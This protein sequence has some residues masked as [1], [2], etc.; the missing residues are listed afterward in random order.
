MPAVLLAHGSPDPRHSEA[1]ESQAEIL[2]ER[3]VE[4]V[5]AYLDHQG[6]SLKEVFAQI[7]EAQAPIPVIPLLI[8]QAFHA[9]VDV[10]REVS[11]LDRSDVVVRS[12]WL[13]DET[14]IAA[15]DSL[16]PPQ[17]SPRDALV[18]VTAGSS[19]PAALSADD[20]RAASWARSRGISNYAA[21][22]ASGPGQRPSTAIAAARAAGAERVHVVT[23]FLAPGILLDRVIADASGV[24]GADSLT[25]TPLLGNEHVTAA[26]HAAASA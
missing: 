25:T 17:I 9:Q 13:T 1:V 10:P 14:V 18:L 15:L 26:L 22:F 4:T 7:C 6:P 16:A 12:G 24:G 2:S 21:A 3:G 20:H 11:A 5:V 19:D 23:A 8:A